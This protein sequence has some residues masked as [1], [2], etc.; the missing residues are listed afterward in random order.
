[1]Q[2]ATIC[3]LGLSSWT[4][5]IEELK[6]YIASFKEPSVALNKMAIQRPKEKFL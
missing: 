3:I 1:M 2:M 4:S 5:K 6:I